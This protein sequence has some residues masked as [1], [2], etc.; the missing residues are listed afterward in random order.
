MAAKFYGWKLLAAYWLVLFSVLGWL[1][2]GSGIVNTWMAERLGF[3]R[4]MLGVPYSVLMLVSGL[5]APLVAM[6]V[7]RKGMR[8]AMIA[9]SLMLLAASLFMALVANSFWAAVFGGGVLAGLGVVAGGA[10]PVQTSTMRWF[11]RRRALAFAIILSAGGIG[12]VFAPPL[13]NYAIS[14]TGDWRTGWWIFAGCAAMSSV[15]AFLFAR[16]QPSD[17]GQQPDGDAVSAVAPVAEAKKT[18]TVH[19][20]DEPWT[21]REA[22][23]S[24]T[25]WLL[26]ACMC[27]MSMGYSWFF[28]HGVAHLQ[29]LGHSKSVAAFAASSMAATT[30]FGKF[31]VGLLGDRVEPRFLFGAAVA[32]FGVGMLLV[33]HARDPLSLYTFGICLGA[34]WGGALT[35]L[36]TILANYYGSQA[37][38]AAVGVTLAVQ[39]PVSAISPALSGYLYDVY[40]S[41]APT[42]YTL[43]ALCFVSALLLTR[44]RPPMRPTVRVA[45][46]A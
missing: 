20:T 41:Y 37:Y 14:R 40:G 16:D 22:V 27:G 26:L 19:H 33:V 39:P 21:G 25:L 3:D 10:L 32:L 24:P 42:L 13:L 5:P 36:M 44:A 38:P 1:P 30:L 31:A 8:F 17:L 9:G 34:G 15:I 46:R 7:V 23:R 45:A 4:T 35:C 43:A 18:R 28:S 29:D 6:L 2:Y 12:G 11:V